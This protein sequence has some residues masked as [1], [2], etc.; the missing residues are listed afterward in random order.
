[1]EIPKITSL[2]I[3]KV[4]HQDGVYAIE[5]SYDRDGIAST[6]LKNITIND[7][8]NLRGHNSKSLVERYVV[9][10]IVDDIQAMNN[11]IDFTNIW[12]MNHSKID[13]IIF[14]IVKFVKDG[15]TITLDFE[16]N[17]TL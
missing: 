15:E 10:D 4:K 7:I 13:S 11:D 9:K 12:V 6:V 1:M 2:S 14:A 16:D 3:H 5:V 8:G 17:D